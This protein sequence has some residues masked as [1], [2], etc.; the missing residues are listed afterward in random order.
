MNFL[1]A[2][3]GLAIKLDIKLTELENTDLFSMDDLNYYLNEACIK[4]WD[5]CYWDFAEMCK[6][7]ALIA[8][9]ITNGY[10][11]YPSDLAPLSINLLRV[12]SIEYKKYNFRDFQRYLEL[13]PTGKDKVWA[14]YNQKIFINL[15]C[16]AVGSVVE[17]YG[18]EMFTI[19]TSDSELLPFSQDVNT[20]LLSGNQAI[21]LLAYAEA[22][23][24]EKKRNP[25]QAVLEEKKA[26]GLLESLRQQ[27]GKGRATE[28]SANRPFF[29]VPNYFGPSAGSGNNL[30]KF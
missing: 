15:N 4:A 3:K 19:L 18:K 7:L 9:D 22:L 25:N 27:F 6:T 30:G 12:D 16:V 20:E 23:S 26:Y 13:N 28:Q 29:N 10:I 24:S 21:V 14:E 1:D 17:L 8:S 2:K 5:Y 11:S